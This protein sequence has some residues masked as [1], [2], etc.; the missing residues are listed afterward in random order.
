MSRLKFLAAVFPIIFFSSSNSYAFSLAEAWKAAVDYSADYSASK[1]ERDAEAEQKRIAR[2]ALL[3]KITANASYQRHPSSSS[4]ETR[5]QGWN[6]QASQ[7]LFDKSRYAQY[8]QGKLAEESANAK[9]D[10][11]EGE[12]LLNVSKAY[13]DVLLQK[14]KLSAIR[15]E[16]SAYE[17]QMKQAKEMFKQ[18]AATI[19]DTHEA[20]SGYDA[21][22]SKEIETLTQLEI[23]ENTLADMTGLNPKLIRTIKISPNN[24]NLLGYTKEQD[25][26]SLAESHNPEWL[27]QKL[28]L[29]S[30]KEGLK[31]AKG[32]HWPT[33]TLNGGYQNNMNT[34]ENEAYGG[35]YKYRSKGGTIS[36]D[37]NMP[38][39][40][41]G[42][43]SSLIRQAAAQ[44]M[45]NQDLLTATERKI[46][47]AIKQAYRSTSSNKILMMAQERLLVTNQAKLDSTKL[48][49]QVGVRNNLEEI[50]AQQNKAEAEQKLA[51][52]K[53]A[54]VQ[55]YLQLLQSAGVLT[56]PERQ[57]QIH[58]TL[59]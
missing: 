38:L 50:Q 3:P 12:L 27:Q 58:Q 21:A 34:V 30:S 13:F 45:Q 14:D 37:V 43:T 59:Y 57:I 29:A 9:L 54:Y 20:K 16:K 6:I 11:K 40:T 26:Q 25:W 55:S 52:A 28:A 51:E 39:Y 49:R 35:E 56:E 7:V 4:S 10:S 41:G 36:V 53:Y 24:T 18:G 1:H 17:Q 5:S 33:V 32:K 19:I 44:E 2:S 48:G 46:K 47:L 42:E 31:A 23:A 22:L 15:K 8:K